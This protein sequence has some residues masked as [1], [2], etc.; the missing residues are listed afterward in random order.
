[1]RGHTDAARAYWRLRDMIVRTE[2]APGAALAEADL[3]E[4]IKVG[5]TPLRDA[6]QRLGHEGLV[7]ILPRRG[8]FVTEVT[9]EDLQQ[10][11]EM[12]WSLDELLARLATDHCTS[13]DLA[14]LERL[15]Q[16]QAAVPV[17]Q[18]APV[19]IDNQVHR[20]LVRMAGN[21]YLAD[22]YRRCQDGTLRLLY[23]TR[24]G[25]ESHAEQRCFLGAVADALA[26]RDAER[27]TATLR[28]HRQR[29]RE[30]LAATIFSPSGRLSAQAS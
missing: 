11:F 7:E 22:P 28:D 21:V 15:M 2:L 1:M 13:A 16:I 6:L 3:M 24:C 18:G 27:L 17:E 26:E 9:I 29:L 12:A 5:R 10:M 30:R 25:R 23:L 19:E 4:R 8:T 20:L 14:E